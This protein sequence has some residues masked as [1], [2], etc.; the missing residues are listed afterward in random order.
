MKENKL[1]HL[2]TDKNSFYVNNVYFYDYNSSIDLFLD[3]NKLLS[4]KYV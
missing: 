4:M 2:L 3:K 1:Y